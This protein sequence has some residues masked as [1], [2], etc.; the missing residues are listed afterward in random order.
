VPCRL[1]RLL[2]VG[3]IAFI[4]FQAF[5]QTSD[6]ASLATPAG[7]EVTFGVGYYD[8]VEPGDTSI[9]IHGPKFEGGYTGTMTL[10][11]AGHWFLQIDARGLYGNTTYDGWCS[12]YL[13][14]PDSRSPNGYALDIGDPSPCN[15]SGDKDWY[16]EGRALVGKD[17]LGNTWGWSPEIGLGIRHLSNGIAGVAGYRTDD[18]LYLPVGITARTFV[19]SQHALSFNLEYDR[20]LHGWQNTRNSLLGGGDVPATPTAPAFTIQG[21]SDISFDQ[22]SGWALRASVQYQMTTHW[23]VKPEYIH[24]NVSASPVNY[25]T[26]TFTVNGITAQEQ[27]GFYEPLNRTDEFVVKLGF[28]F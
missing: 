1:K 22:H 26:A 16:V 18:Y 19:A 12:P 14:T 6:Q 8:Y 3:P 11:P 27:L 28:R 9:S 25:G 10:N 2:V 17:F 7:H 5:A 13:I 4:P 21:F 23:S 24:W 15:E 20:L